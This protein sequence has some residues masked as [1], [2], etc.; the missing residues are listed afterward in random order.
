MRCYAFTDE[1]GNT[2]LNL[3]DTDQESF[4]TGTLI[5]FVDLDARYKSLHKELLTLAGESELHGAHLGF[6]GIEK[7]A[8]RLA[9]FIR[10]K[11]LL[12]SFVRVHKPFLAAAKLFDLAF[13]AGNN[14]AMV[15][16][17]YWTRVLRAMTL[18]HFVQL[19]D[20]ADLR[21][22]WALFSA[23][24]PQPF[25]VFLG[26]LVERV[27][28]APYDPR[29]LKVL[30]DALIWASQHPEAVLDP[31]GERDSPNLAAFSRLF[32]HLHSLNETEGH[33]IGSFVHDEQNQFI[34]M[35]QEYYGVLSKWQFTMHPLGLVTD[36]KPLPTFN[37]SLMVRSS[38]YS[39]G[40]QLID[41]C[42]WIIKRVIEKGDKPRGNCRTLFDC[43]A[44]RA[45]ISRFDF[46][47]LVENVKVGVDYVGRLPVTDEQ[48][49]AGRTVAEEFERKRLSRIAEEA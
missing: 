4:W 16:H 5:A 27:E 18:M 48:I 14:P 31:F 11:K 9:W 24:D 25:G 15:S 30:S 13:D 43:L 3:F 33:V 19:L 37:C 38:T 28:L 8:A 6:G 46:T 40:L 42:M 45:W 12:F 41:I 20:L 36:V 29:T 21:E 49:E 34:P 47:D 26:K 17:V 39:F 7:I 22:F 35:I 1:S 23:Q 2:G 10:E 44:G 32:H